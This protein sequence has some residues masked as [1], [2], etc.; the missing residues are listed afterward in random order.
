[1]INLKNRLMNYF[2]EPLSPMEIIQLVASSSILFLTIL[3][4]FFVFFYSSHI[5]NKPSGWRLQN[6]FD[7]STVVPTRLNSDNDALARPIFN[8]SR[9]PNPKE[10]L[11]TFDIEN[12]LSGSQTNMHVVAIMKFN[13]DTMAFIQ[14]ADAPEGT[15]VKVGDILDGKK[16]K[17]INSTNVILAEG[18]NDLRLSL[19]NSHGSDS[20]LNTQPSQVINPQTPRQLRR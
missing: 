19:Y 16:I 11:D 5:N 17:K 7:S 3:N 2:Q 9:R 1:M 15:W 20:I 18:E 10:K 4:L 14:T 12:S 6:N 8:K 13:K